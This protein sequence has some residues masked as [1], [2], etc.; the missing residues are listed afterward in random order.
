LIA[1]GLS[2]HTGSS[3]SSQ[4]QRT[5]TAI[6]G[7]QAESKNQQA[8]FSQAGL[9]LDFL[10]DLSKGTL[11]P[12][13]VDVILEATGTE[14]I[15]AQQNF[16]GKVSKEQYRIVLLGLMG[17]EM[18]HV[19]PLAS[20]ER[21]RLGASR[22]SQVWQSWRWALEHTELLGERTH[23][24]KD[25][26]VYGRAM[27]IAESFLPR[28][29]ESLP[30]VFFVMG[31]RVGFAAIADQIYMDVLNMTFSRAYRGRA[32]ITDSEVIEYFAHEMHHVGFG[33]IF[34]QLHHDLSLDDSEERAF[35]FLEGIAAEG[36]ATYLIN[37]H[38]S[39][40]SLRQSPSYARYFEQGDTLL[41]IAED[42]LRK[43]LSGQIVTD[44]EYDRV[45]TIQLEHGYHVTG[46]MIFHVIDQAGGM[47]SM[48]KVISDPRQLLAEYNAAAE[49]L[50]SEG[51]T[52]YLFDTDLA[53]MVS[54]IGQLD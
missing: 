19:E 31:G 6:H 1:V 52:V 2:G 36:S 28:P 30:Q 37:G 48:M 5:R 42:V 46:S 13:K 35:R 11:K 8:D 14:L 4:I 40:E 17:D 47:E 18:P 43:L 49:K 33:E 38:Q 44:D 10:R 32:H 51:E 26:D 50:E 54:V 45:N 39:I 9:V 34:E 22:L 53:R 21:A 41:H 20:S 23:A 15:I 29:L 12:E 25:L 16:R 27:G 7:A 24:L 3:A